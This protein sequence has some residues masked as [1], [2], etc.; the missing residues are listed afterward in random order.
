MQIQVENVRQSAITIA[1]I[2]V[3][4]REVVVSPD[5]HDQPVT[6]VNQLGKCEL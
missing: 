5:V 4:H 1:G 3:Q 6:V 2:S